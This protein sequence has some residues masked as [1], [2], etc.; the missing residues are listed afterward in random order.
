[1]LR[2][3]PQPVHG[4]DAGSEAGRDGAGVACEG[5]TGVTG[6][7]RDSGLSTAGAVP[8]GG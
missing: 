3:M 5:A 8:R 2:A 4:L 1:M 7:S 6:V